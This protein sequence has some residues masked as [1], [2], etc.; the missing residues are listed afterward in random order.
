MSRELLTAMFA[1]PWDLSSFD[2]ACGLDTGNK[3]NLRIEG[4]AACG[5]VGGVHEQDTWWSGRHDE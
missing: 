3:V 2:E 1:F 4:E 5:E